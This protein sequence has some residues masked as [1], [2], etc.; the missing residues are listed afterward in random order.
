[1]DQFARAGSEPLRSPMTRAVA[2]G[3]F[4]FREGE[5][6]T[7]VYR[8]EEGA[9]CVYALANRSHQPFIEFAY[10]GDWIGFGYLEAH[11]C[12]ARAVAPSRVSCL[13]LSAIGAIVACDE[14]AEEQ[15][16]A[17]LER[18]F[19]HVRETTRA[20]EPANPLQ[21]VAAFLLSLSAISRNEGRDP[22]FIVE[23]TR[24]GL[25]ADCLTM[26]L[27]TLS[28][29]LVELERR[30]LIEPHVPEGLRI[31]DFAALEAIAD[32]STNAPAATARN[33]GP[34]LTGVDY[35]EIR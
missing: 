19:A 7:H 14:R 3:S 9:I 28:S 6:K 4:L 29:S 11:V 16:K 35:V 5:A 1:M 12:R 31:R 26:S 30:G 27:E 24:S 20:R 25:V 33:A 18:E 13:P 2:G 10:P 8:V 23:S 22:S 21:R 15:L 32:V 17:A 34:N